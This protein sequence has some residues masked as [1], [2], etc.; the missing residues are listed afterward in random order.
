MFYIKNIQVNLNIDHKLKKFY[1]LINHKKGIRRI[2]IS[3]VEN[4][5]LKSL[6]TWFRNNVNYILKEE[7]E[8]GV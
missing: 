2:I 1:W 8:N 5:S 4:E 6:H 7:L 3:N